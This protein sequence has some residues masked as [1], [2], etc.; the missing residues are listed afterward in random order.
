[1]THLRIDMS[2]NDLSHID[3]VADEVGS[4]TCQYSWV[5]RVITWGLKYPI[6]EGESTVLQLL[7]ILMLRGRRIESETLWKIAS[8]AWDKTEDNSYH[9]YNWPH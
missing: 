1:M 7:H 4:D 5:V 9:T 8:L 3:M 6:E 2:E